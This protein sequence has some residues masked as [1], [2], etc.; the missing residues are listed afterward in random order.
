MQEDQIC[1]AA[2]MYFLFA[3]TY[4]SMKRSILKIKH[5]ARVPIIMGFIWRFDGVTRD[6]RSYP[7]KPFVYLPVTVTITIWFNVSLEEPRRDLGVNCKDY[8]LMS[9]RMSNSD[10][11]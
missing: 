1:D 8:F 2:R 10:A 4:I 3:K 6:P 11:H 9:T 7:T 5:Q